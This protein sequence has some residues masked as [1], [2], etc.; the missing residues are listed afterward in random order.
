[1][2]DTFDNNRDAYEFLRLCSVGVKHDISPI[3]PIYG[4]DWLSTLLA[5]WIVQA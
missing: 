1:M 3:W 4:L 5:D 2:C